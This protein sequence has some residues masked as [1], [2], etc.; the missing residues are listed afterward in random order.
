[1]KTFILIAV[2]LL[3]VGCNHNFKNERIDENQN[4]KKQ[5]ADLERKLRIALHVNT[6]WARSKALTSKASEKEFK[7]VGM[8]DKDTDTYAD[9][10]VF[11]LKKVKDINGKVFKTWEVDEL[12]S[13]DDIEG[14]YYKIPCNTGR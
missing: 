1:M 5:V 13:F 8:Y 6:C 14:Q 9:L 10:R 11:S 7:M 2:L 4:L 3:T 12:T